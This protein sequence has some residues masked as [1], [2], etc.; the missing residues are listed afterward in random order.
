MQDGSM[1]SL[2]RRVARIRARADA[3]SPRAGTRTPG[4]ALLFHPD[5]DRRL[6]HRTRSADPRTR[7]HAAGALAGCCI[8]ADT[9]GGEFRP[10]LRT[11]PAGEGW[12]GHFRRRARRTLSRACHRSGCYPPIAAVIR[13][14]VVIPAL[15]R[16]PCTHFKN[17]QSSHREIQKRTP[18][19]SST[20]DPWPGYRPHRVD[21]ARCH[22]PPSGPHRRQFPGC[23]SA[24]ERPRHRRP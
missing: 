3:G 20:D 2:R 19:P 1:V 23:G 21:A 8:A 4:V 17:P 12:R 10:A 22:R 16:D 6:W 24:A 14:S 18:S 5:C 9:A 13:L 11:L 15:S 7:W